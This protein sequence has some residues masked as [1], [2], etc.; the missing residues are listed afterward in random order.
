MRSFTLALVVMLTLT[1]CSWMPFFGDEDEDSECTPDELI[2]LLEE[3]IRW[4][5][6]HKRAVDRY[7]RKRNGPTWVRVIEGS[8]SKPAP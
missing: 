7:L 1:G 6:A 3:R 8:K 2:G 4:V 5:E